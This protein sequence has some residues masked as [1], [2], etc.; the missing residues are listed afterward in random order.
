VKLI[1]DGLYYNALNRALDGQPE[2]LEA[3]EGILEVV[4]RITSAG[5]RSRE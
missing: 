3:D 2:L 1:G 4:D 5:R